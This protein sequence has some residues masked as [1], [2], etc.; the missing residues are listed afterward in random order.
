MAH[1]KIYLL[2]LLSV[3]IVYGQDECEYSTNGILDKK[4]SDRFLAIKEG[5]IK[6]GV[7][8]NS[9]GNDM[10][11]FGSNLI[12]GTAI[13]IKKNGSLILKTK[14]ETKEVASGEIISF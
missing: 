11:I 12:K 7:K 3:F 8:V 5:L 6:C 13:D 1:E 2:A 10:E 9:K 14:N 4:E